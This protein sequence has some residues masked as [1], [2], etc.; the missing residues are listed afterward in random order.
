MDPLISRESAEPLGNGARMIGL[1]PAFHQAAEADPPPQ[2]NNGLA[3]PG[4]AGR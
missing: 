2:H 3:S 4:G 1:G